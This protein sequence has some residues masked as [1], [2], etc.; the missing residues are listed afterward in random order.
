MSSVPEASRVRASARRLRPAA[1]TF[2]IV[3]IIV[4]LLGHDARRPGAMADVVGLMAFLG[5]VAVV[6]SSY[7]LSEKDQFEPLSACGAFS[8][9]MLAVIGNQRIPGGV[10]VAVYLLIPLL[11]ASGS[12]L[13][14]YLRRRT[15]TASPMLAVLAGNLALGAYIAIFFD[16]L[17]HRSEALLALLSL[18]LLG[19]G[20]Q[21]VFALLP[22]RIP[23]SSDDGPF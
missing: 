16:S 13:G 3:A 21:V 14:A 17:P 15:L 20:V 22:R 23:E 2:V 5:G 4:T 9:L 18:T 10:S 7:F 6:L 11:A 12:L 8:G 1:I 19:A